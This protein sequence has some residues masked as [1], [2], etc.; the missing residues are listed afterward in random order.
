MYHRPLLNENIGY[1]KKEIQIRIDRLDE[2]ILSQLIDLTSTLS[3]VISC[4]TEKTVNQITTLDS[5]H[6]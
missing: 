4:N 2:A 3:W 6:Q 5:N 1:A